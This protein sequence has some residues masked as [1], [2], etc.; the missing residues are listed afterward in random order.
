MSKTSIAEAIVAW[1][2]LLLNV[3]ASAADAP[4]IDVYAAPLEKML[5]DAKVLS[6]SLESRKALK[7][8]ES[9]D[10]K[11][12]MQ[13]GNVQASRIRSSLKAFFGPHSERIIEFGGRP[14][15]PRKNKRP[16]VP[17]T[18]PA[19]PEP[20]TPEAAAKTGADTPRAVAA[21]PSVTFTS[22][23]AEKP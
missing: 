1:E 12:L 14:I 8:Q 17:E 10:R 6:A 20:P 9:K 13:M 19:V 21:P 11:I 22:K 2:K 16:V 4:D 3:K 7:Q 23:T 5:A 18:P 15:R